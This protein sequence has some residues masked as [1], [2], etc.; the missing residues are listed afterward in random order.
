M[1]IPYESSLPVFCAFDLGVDDFTACWFYQCYRNEIR[2]IRFEQ[3]QNIGLLD[4]LKEVSQYN[5]VYATLYVPWDIGRRE[6]SSAKTTLD[7]IQDL[8]FDVFTV[9]RDALINGINRVREI[10]TQCYFDEVMCADGIDCLEN[11]RKKSNPR[12]GEFLDTPVHD[13][14]SHGADAFRYLAQ[15]YDPYLG[16]QFLQNKQVHFMKRQHKVIRSV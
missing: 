12:T 4:I 3:W 5:Y 6:L 13:D 14:F 9:P 11:Y 1:R 16:E 15:A 7:I 8:G 10:F 2:L